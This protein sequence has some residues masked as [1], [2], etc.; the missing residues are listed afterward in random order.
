MA[1]AREITCTD[2]LRFMHNTGCSST[3]SAAMEQRIETVELKLM[4]LELAV[5]QLND[6]VI[7][8]Q[9][10]IDL[11]SQKIERYQR[12]LEAMEPNVAPDSEE[13]PPPHY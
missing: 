8:Q 2:R 3:D 12:M 7:H 6:V 10:T 1:I 5:E 9:Q 4:D 11:L 13:T